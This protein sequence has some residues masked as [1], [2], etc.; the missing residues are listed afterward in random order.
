MAELMFFDIHIN[1]H[2]STSKNFLSI[3]GVVTNSHKFSH[4]GEHSTWKSVRDLS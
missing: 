1:V 2:L 3:V 4:I